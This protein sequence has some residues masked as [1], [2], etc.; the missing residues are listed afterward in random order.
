MRAGFFSRGDGEM[1]RPLID[2]L[3]HQD[4]YMVLADFKAYLDCQA[5][6]DKAYAD[7]EH[8]THMS[9]LNTARS[10]PCS[11]DR[12]IGEYSNEIWNRDS[13]PIRLLNQDEV[14]V[15]IPQ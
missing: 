14:N 12:T 11:S 3:L 1:F 9:I 5:Q 13:V 15:S 4:Q 7:K 10:G 8:W 2:G 6:V